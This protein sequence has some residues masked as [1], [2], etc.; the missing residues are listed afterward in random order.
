MNSAGTS[1]QA[2]DV[3][4]SLADSTAMIEFDTECRVGWVNQRFAHALDN[5]RKGQSRGQHIAEP[6][7]RVSTQAR[8]LDASAQRVG[9]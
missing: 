2:Q 6:F 5:L 8:Q 3:P 9:A 7:R 1:L 4:G